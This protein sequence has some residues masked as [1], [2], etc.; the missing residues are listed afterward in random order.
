MRVR[1]VDY[2]SP[3]AAAE[4]SQGLKETGFAV[5]SNHPIPTVLIDEAYK[6]WYAFFKSDDKNDFAF[7]KET[8][9]GYV[10]TQLSETAKGYSTKDI[11]EFYHYYLGRR[12]PKACVDVTS[13]LYIELNNMA[14][15][16][17]NW[18]EENSPAEIKANYSMPLSKMIKDCPNSLF[19]IIHYPPLNGHEPKDA[20]RAA[21]HEDINLITLLPA[22]T[23]DGLQV[24]DSE[25]NW[26]DVPINPGW[27]IVNIADMLQECSGFYYP[28]TSHRVLNPTGENAKKSRLSMPFFL[29]ANDDVVLSSRHTAA[30]YRAERFRELGLK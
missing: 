2:H 13:Q 3:N 29:H 17:L 16:L 15:T 14:S 23:A 7:Y 10:S 4:F 1:V 27:I 22:A 26:L 21:A 25:G 5:L 28:S 19:R 24:K 6:L 18:I 8:H 9:D 12:C 30:S 11:K 20:M